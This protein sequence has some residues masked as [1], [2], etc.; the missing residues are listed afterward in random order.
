MFPN[1]ERSWNEERDHVL[2]FRLLSSEAKT[3]LKKFLT[4][5]HVVYI[6]I[7]VKNHVSVHSGRKV[8]IQHVHRCAQVF[9]MATNIGILNR[10]VP[11]FMILES[12]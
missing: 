7:I 3:T 4:Q 10:Q 6:I 1:R 2:S 11:V 9:N 8:R 5:V 12:E